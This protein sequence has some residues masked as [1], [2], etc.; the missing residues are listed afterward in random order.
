MQTDNTNTELSSY[1]SLD[2]HFT[3][4]TNYRYT[5][6]SMFHNKTGTRKIITWS[7]AKR[8]PQEQSKAILTTFTKCTI[9]ILLG[10]GW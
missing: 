4:M 10:Q 3:V 5:K 6:Y 9:K 1:V 7:K 8:S 2:L